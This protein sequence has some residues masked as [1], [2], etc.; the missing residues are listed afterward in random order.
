MLKTIVPVAKE[1]KCIAGALLI[2]GDK[3][4]AL[5]I[6]EMTSCPQ[7]FSNLEK[8]LIGISPRTLS[9]RLEKL[10]DH[11]IIDKTIYCEK[12]PRYNYH[13]TKKG[14]GLKKILEDMVVWSDNYS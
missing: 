10:I 8:N 13:L 2:L 1:K 5:I 9:Q 12:P 3:W 6:R 4:T 11:Q 7:K 14:Q